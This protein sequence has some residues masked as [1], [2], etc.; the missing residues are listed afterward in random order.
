MSHCTK[1][2]FQYTSRKIIYRPL[3]TLGLVWNIDIAT[4]EIKQISNGLTI[5]VWRNCKNVKTLSSL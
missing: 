1:F 4:N 2:D 3:E 5:Y